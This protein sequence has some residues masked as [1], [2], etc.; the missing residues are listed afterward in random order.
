MCDNDLNE[1]GSNP[2]QE[3]A[4]KLTEMLPDAVRVSL[5]LGEDVNSTLVNQGAQY[6]ADLVRA[7]E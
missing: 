5:P 7:I 4:K 1:D 2:G 6:L 3:L